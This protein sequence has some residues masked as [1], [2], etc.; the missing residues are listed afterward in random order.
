MLI[1]N[2]GIPNSWPAI[3]QGDIPTISAADGEI[4]I[5]LNKDN[6]GPTAEYERRL[7]KRLNEKFTDMEFFFQPANIISQIINSASPPRSICS[8]R[9]QRG[10]ELQGCPAARRT[11]LANSRRRRCP[12][13]PGCRAAGVADQC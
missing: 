11:D 10:S 8:G 9:P 6:H 12:R 7:R 3:A 1:D 5:A 2:I 13:A 4:L